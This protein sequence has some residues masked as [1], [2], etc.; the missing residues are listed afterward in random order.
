MFK[1]CLSSL[2]N[3]SHQI[4][5]KL[6]LGT[7]RVDMGWGSLFPYKSIQTTFLWA[8]IK[9]SQVPSG[10]LEMLLVCCNALI[11]KVYS[12]N[13]L[14]I[15]LYGSWASKFLFLPSVIFFYSSF[16]CFQFLEYFPQEQLKSNALAF[17]LSMCWP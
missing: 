10:Y 2:H 7:F 8:G 6:E 14:V 3:T 4:L 12:P 16:C 13:E 9:W 17:C 11:C 15:H 1:A 5:T